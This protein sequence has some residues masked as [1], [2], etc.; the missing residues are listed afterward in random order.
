MT[1]E[2]IKAYYQ[3][4]SEAWKYFRKWVNNFQDDESFWQNAVSE[5]EKFAEQYKEQGLER[6]AYRIAYDILEELET[7]A[8][9]DRNYPKPQRK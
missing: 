3:M 2:D 4:W 7:E 8:I 9:M 6:F 1:Q 5:A